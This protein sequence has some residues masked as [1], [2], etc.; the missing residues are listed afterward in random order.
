MHTGHGTPDGACKLQLPHRDVCMRVAKGLPQLQDHPDLDTPDF[1]KQ[2]GL[3]GVMCLPGFLGAY[4]RSW[5]GSHLQD[6]VEDWEVFTD[7]YL[8][9]VEILLF[10]LFTVHCGGTYQEDHL[11]IHF[12][13][14]A[15]W[16]TKK[17]DDEEDAGFTGIPINQWEYLQLHTYKQY[18][19]K[20]QTPK[21]KPTGF[22]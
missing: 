6:A 18:P 7:Q 1:W 15:Y 8:Q 17:Q 19:F 10:S 11:K 22:L 5:P 14:L 13:I 21:K 20:A 4:V 2:I 9:P 12:Y 16:D 3:A